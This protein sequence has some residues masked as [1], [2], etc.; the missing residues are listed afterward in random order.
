[1]NF[2]S[3]TISVIA[4]ECDDRDGSLDRAKVDLLEQNGFVCKMRIYPGYDCICKHKD[5][6]PSIKPG[7]ELYF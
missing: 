6:N 7:V 5:Y 3:V 1:M 4:M 2:E